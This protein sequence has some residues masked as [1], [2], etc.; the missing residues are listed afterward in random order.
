M[1]HN[2]AK[3]ANADARLGRLIA[4]IPADWGVQIERPASGGWSVALERP[5]EGVTWGMPQATLQAA[6]EDAWRLV[7]PPES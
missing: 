5:S 2:Y 3:P 1:S 7:G 6:L 4:R